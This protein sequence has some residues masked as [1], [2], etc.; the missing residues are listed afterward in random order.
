MIYTSCEATLCAGWLFRARQRLRLEDFGVIC[1][2]KAHVEAC[3]A[4]AKAG[5][6]VAEFA[7]VDAFQGGER[8][9]IALCCGRLSTQKHESE[10]FNVEV[11][12]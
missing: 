12:D 3:A 4:A 2:Y 11:K 9:V 1:L 7:T 6:M 8:E 5:G 10:M